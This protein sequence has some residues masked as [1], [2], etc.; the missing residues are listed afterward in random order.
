[1]E[2]R[3]TEIEDLNKMNNQLM[4]RK[5]QDVVGTRKFNNNIVIK[6]ADGTVAME[7]EE[8]KAGRHSYFLHKDYTAL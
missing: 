8:I 4:Y 7:V 3:C 1:M 6:K 2:E 5:V